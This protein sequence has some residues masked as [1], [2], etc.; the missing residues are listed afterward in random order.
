MPPKAKF[1]KDQIVEAALDIVREG[2]VEA[3][4]AQ[5]M[6]KQL[7]TSTR[8]MFTYFDT[9][10]DLRTAATDAAWRI[11]DERARQGLALTPA[12]KGFGMAFVRFAVEEP[13]LFRL[14]FMRKSKHMSIDEHLEREGHLDVVLDAVMS[15]FHIGRDQAKWLYENML[16]YVHGIAAMCASEAVRF[17]D[18][19]V[20]SR[21]GL[22]CR[23]LLMGMSE[24]ANEQTAVMPGPDVVFDGSLENYLSR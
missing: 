13:S 20:A 6:A 23:G 19:E 24:P 11:Y 16:I 3:I 22:L 1:T 9:V 15:T 8:P 14:L 18:E 7:G 2:G 21:L 4:T 10:E 17:T 12:F 5:A